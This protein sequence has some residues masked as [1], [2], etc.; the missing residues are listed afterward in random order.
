MEEKALIS[1]KIRTGQLLSL[2]IL[3]ASKDAKGCLRKQN[4]AVV[5]VGTIKNEGVEAT[6]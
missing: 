6:F 3:D 2:R 1:G 4:I 5:N